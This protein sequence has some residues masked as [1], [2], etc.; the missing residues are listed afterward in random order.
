MTLALHVL[1]AGTAL[2]EP[3]KVDRRLRHGADCQLCYEG[4]SGLELAVPLWIPIVGLDG[5]WTGA[6]GSSELVTLDAQVQF[7]IVAEAR[8]RLGPV[9]VGISANG[10]S[11]GSPLVR[12]D[13][14]EALGELDMSLFFGRVELDWYTPPYRLGLGKRPPLLAIWPYMGVR[15]A[16]LSASAVNAEQ[17]LALEGRYHWAEPL[18]GLNLLLDLRRGWLFKLKGDL[19]GFSVGSDIS[20]WA[21]AEV[22]Y[23]VL[24]WLNFRAGWVLY[25]VRLE[26]GDLNA[27]L[28]LQGPTAGFGL[29]L[30]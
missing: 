5:A 27:D 6:S 12:T 1:V 15:Y 10:A 13:T 26:V 18:F 30:F 11:L 22:Q 2:A 29:P 19:G 8:L 23:A 28:V 20:V 21:A 4:A 16:L 3:E 14:G 24:D 25:A 9:G 7:A 17:D